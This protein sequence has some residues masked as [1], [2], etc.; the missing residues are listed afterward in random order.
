MMKKVFPI[1]FWNTASAIKFGREGVQDWA[2]FGTTLTMTGFYE[3][4]PDKK[5]MTEILDECYAKGIQII[6]VDR[7]MTYENISS[8]DFE[9]VMRQNIADFG[10]HPA[11]YGFYLG[12]EPG[13]N[14]IEDAIKTV[15]LFR[16]LCPDKEPFINLL[17]WCP[18]HCEKTDDSIMLSNHTTN[19]KEKIVDF[20]RRSGVRILSYDCYMQMQGRIS[21]DKWLDAYFRNLNIF[22]EAAAETG[23]ELWFTTLA[24]AHGGYRCPSQD[25]LRWEISTAVAH[26]VQ[27][28]FYWFMY[29]EPY[30]INYRLHPINQFNERTDTFRWASEENRIFQ[31][32]YGSLFCELKLDKVYHIEKTYG[33]TPLLS[34]GND[35]FIEEVRSYDEDENFVPAILSRFTREGDDKIYYALVNNSTVSPTSTHIKFSDQVQYYRIQDNW[36]DIHVGLAATYEKGQERHFWCSPGQLWVFAVKKLDQ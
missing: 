19:Y 35:E 13:G 21:S 16:E 9:T 10:S 6:L 27:G 4:E 17:P 32:I 23:A 14:Y 22:Q 15:H 1:G 20:I 34:E 8:S 30:N 3:Y 18:W 28:L 33:G 24:T 31:M 12:D 2:D 25:D 36:E 26:G 29:A 11:I 7:R 5:K